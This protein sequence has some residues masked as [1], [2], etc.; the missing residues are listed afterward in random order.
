M[1]QEITER[2]KALGYIVTES[3]TWMLPF[4]VSKVESDVKIA[5][6]LSNIPEEL[7]KIVIDKIVGE[8]LLNKKSTGQ[9][10][11]FDLTPAVSSITEGDTSLSFDT[12]Q[13]DERKLNMLINYLMTHGD[14]AL[15]SFRC[16]KW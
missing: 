6:N 11:G 10:E 5:C 15:S 4:I 13:S 8:F 1:L 9:L 12:S 3:D 2:L 14:S 16:L 7:T